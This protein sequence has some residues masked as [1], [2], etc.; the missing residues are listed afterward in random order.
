[1]LEK[2]YATDAPGVYPVVDEPN[3]VTSASAAM[4]LAAH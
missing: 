2:W 4:A 1:V 3:P